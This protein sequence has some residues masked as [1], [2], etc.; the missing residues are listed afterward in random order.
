[1][2]K[3]SDILTA[4]AIDVSKIKTQKNPT[5]KQNR[6]GC[7]SDFSNNGTHNLIII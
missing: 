5:T 6:E 7:S 4:D 1:V 3:I 2:I